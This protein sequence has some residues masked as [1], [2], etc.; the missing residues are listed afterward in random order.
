[1]LFELIKLVVGDPACSEGRGSRLKDSSDLED[2]KCSTFVGNLAHQIEAAE[3]A[4]AVQISDIATVADSD[5]DDA[6]IREHPHRFAERPAR[7][8]HLGREV[9]FGRESLAGVKVPRCDETDDSVDG[10]IGC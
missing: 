5:V 9:S 7:D 2:L 1:M 10:A 4:F 8:P 6:K 3:Q